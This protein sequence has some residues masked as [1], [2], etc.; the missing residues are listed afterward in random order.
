[1]NKPPIDHLLAGLQGTDAEPI[2]RAAV[3]CAA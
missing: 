1:M 3:R 2:C